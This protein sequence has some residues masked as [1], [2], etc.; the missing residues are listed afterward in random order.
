M[1]E[2]ALLEVETKQHLNNIPPPDNLKV[3]LSIPL[4]AAYLKRGYNENQIATVC[5]ISR[6]AV[7][8]YI[9]RHEEEL[10]PL[11]ENDGYLA[12]RARNIACKAMDRIDIN[13]DSTTQ[14][15]LIALNAISGTH[16]DKYRLL[17]GQSTDNISV[18]I[19]DN[20]RMD[21]QQIAQEMAKKS[22]QA[23]KVD[24]VCLDNKP[25]VNDEPDNG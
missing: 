12:L 23:S 16:V 4:I 14:K 15:D 25:L 6:Q 8:E 20:E 22:V 10:L 9:S 18:K 19:T 11:I 1:S 5:N 2:Q 24:S 7:N 21:L 17:S 3:K 13:L